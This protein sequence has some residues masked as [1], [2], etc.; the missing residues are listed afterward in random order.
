MRA[1]TVFNFLIE[2]T[3]MG[4]V[5]ILILLLVRRFLRPQLGSRLLCV[6][7]LLV[8]ARL[9]VPLSLPNPVMNEIRPDL[10]GNMDVRPIADQIRVRV[11]DASYDVATV[12]EGAGEYRS[13]AAA[14]VL[15]DFGAHTSYGHTARWILLGYVCVCV[16]VLACMT[17][18]NVRFLRKLHRDRVEALSGEEKNA[19]IHLCARRNVKP[20]PVYWVDP[21]PSACLAGVLRPWIALPLTLD[22]S[23]LNYVLAHELCHKKAGDHWWGI[24]RNLC[25]IVHWF[26]PLVWLAAHL[27]RMDQELAC[28]ER[29]TRPLD[30][31]Q[32]IDYAN[33]LAIEAARRNAPRMAV[34]ATGMT[35]KGREIKRRIRAIVDGRSVVAWLCIAALCVAG[36]GTLFSF[37]T[38]EVLPQMEPLN[39]RPLEG[40]PVQLRTIADE[41]AAVAYARELLSSEPYLV[42]PELG[43]YDSFSML[44]WSAIHAPDSR[45]WQVTAEPA[46]FTVTF[47][48]DGKLYQIL[49]GNYEINGNGKSANPSYRTDTAARQPLYDYVQ[50]CM[51]IL[52]PDIQPEELY[53]DA[54]YWLE[55]VRYVNIR[56][57]G[58]NICSFT[59]ALNPQVYLCSVSRSMEGKA[60]WYN[61]VYQVRRQQ[62][63]QEKAE[64]IQQ[65]SDA[66]A[67]EYVPWDAIEPDSALA[68]AAEHANN[69]LTEVYSYSTEQA[70]TFLY[71]LQETENGTYCLYI[72][73]QFPQWPYGF[74]LDDL[75]GTAFTPYRQNHVVRSEGDLRYFW[76]RVEKESWLAD[77]GQQ[78]RQLFV[79]E[80]SRELYNIVLSEEQKAAVLSGEY[81]REE[82]ITA[83][84]VSAYEDMS[85]WNEPLTAWYE[86]TLQR[87]QP[88]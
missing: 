5:M 30:D 8:A 13:S 28:D 15:R 31:R 10:S 37:G 54:D 14:N 80:L 36:A 59:L 9:L 86:A 77:W 18:Q 1:A 34:L 81:S 41:E 16:L 69:Y 76:D 52:M 23:E 2:S 40:E 6:A 20:V 26:N 70:D 53:V 68:E 7:W 58:K 17:M 51:K 62:A 25:C 29:V 12:L 42:S 82:T 63:Q 19:Y 50:E 65:A 33:T 39:I 67:V 88:R 60:D 49:D 43:K 83:C 74:C 35:M 75:H 32:R 64:R 79:Q 24:V 61:E 46:S 3:L 4:S 38:A 44:E 47:G 22:R 66:L 73:P 56:S 57:E 45:V 71:A 85:K 84:F 87:F 48:E 72:D 78:D 27:S 21:L 55:G 11:I